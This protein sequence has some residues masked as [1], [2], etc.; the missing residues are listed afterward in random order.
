[1]D[2]LLGSPVNNQT[3]F[4][5]KVVSHDLNH[6][7]RWLTTVLQYE[8]DSLCGFLKLSRTYYQNTKDASFMNAN[9][10]NI[11]VPPEKL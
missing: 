1:M 10:T 9:C 6:A 11:F 5:C 2:H 4:E 3:V 7:G 8:L